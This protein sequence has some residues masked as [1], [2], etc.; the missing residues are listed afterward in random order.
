MA[1]QTSQHDTDKSTKQHIFINRSFGLLWSGQT[2][3]TLG[4]H[5]TDAGI[6]LIAILVLGASPAQVGLLIALSALPSL[7]FSLPIGVWVDRLPRR[8]LMLLADLLRA[9]LLLSL[10]LATLSGQLHLG[11]LYLVTI[12]LSSCTLCFDTAYQSFLPQIVESE[13]LIEGNSKLGS[14]NA[15]AEIGGPPLA[16]G[17]IQVLGAPLAMLFDALSFLLSALSIGMMRPREIQHVTPAKQKAS[18]WSEMREGLSTLYGHPLLRTL[19]I[20]S[21]VRTFCGGAFAALYMIYIV[22][23]LDIAPAGY[24]I[25][26]ALGGVGALL[27]S[28]VMPHLT[29]RWGM[30][31]TLIYGALLDSLFALLTPLASGP[32]IVLLSMLGISQLCG[33]IGFVLYA[34]NEISLRQLSLPV[35]VQ[36]RVNAVLSFLVEGIA[37]IG[38]L[39][40]GIVSVYIGIR[41]TLLLGAAGMLLISIWL[42]LTLTLTRR[43]L[44]ARKPSGST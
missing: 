34:L 19:A 5:I 12:V 26:V 2:I 31:R 40:A 8:P 21:T 4:S 28:L 35:A 9:L 10:P 32:T 7:L 39:L 17:L 44:P 24:G 3:S 41:T 36:G 18:V 37:P 27:G 20:Y 25:L 15:L 30:K 29:Q 6:P 1:L 38:T 22:R 43:P 13:R 33:D 14:S 16:G 11:Q 42:A 23:A